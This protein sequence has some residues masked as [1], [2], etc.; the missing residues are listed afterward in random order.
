MKRIFTGSFA[1]LNL[2]SIMS[3]DQDLLFVS[4]ASDLRILNRRLDVVFDT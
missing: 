4:S 3:N 2:H 1:S